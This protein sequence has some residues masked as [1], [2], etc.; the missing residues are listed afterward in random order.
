MRLRKWLTTTLIGISLSAVGCSGASHPSAAARPRSAGTVAETDSA[1]AQRMFDDARSKML[2]AEAARTDAKPGSPK[3][4]TREKAPHIRLYLEAATAFRAV[5]EKYPM[6]QLSY[7]A[8]FSLAEALYHA[9]KYEEAAR[10]YRWVRDHRELGTAHSD[11][12][13][14]GVVDSYE[15][16]IEQ[17]QA[18]GNAQLPQVPSADDLADPSRTQPIVMGPLYTEVQRA[19]DESIAFARSPTEAGRWALQA[20]F[21]SLRHREMDDA[22]R[23]LSDVMNSY[24]RTQAA[25]VAKENLLIIYK[26]RGD[27]AKYDGL[28]RANV[29]CTVARADKLAGL[30]EPHKGLDA[31]MKLYAAGKLEQAATQFEAIAAKAPAGSPLREVAMFDAGV[32]HQEAGE[33]NGAVRVLAPFVD[34]AD[35]ASSP[36]RLEA[37]F[38]LAQAYQVTPDPDRAVATFLRFHADSAAPTAL[39]RAQFDLAAARSDALWMAASMRERQGKYVDP[40]NTK[41]STSAAALYQRFADHQASEKQPDS[42][43]RSADALFRLA[44]VYEKAGQ[45]KEMI[46]TLDRWRRARPTEQAE[47]LALMTSYFMTAKALDRAGDR[48]GADKNYQ[49]TI[50]VYQDRKLAEQPDLL[51]AQLAGEAGFNIAEH[52]F[53]RAERIEVP[54][55]GSL[56]G[57]SG[58]NN[59]TAT[60][61]AYREITEEIAK[62]YREV[63]KL[64]SKWS[65]AAHVRLGDLAYFAG[66]KLAETPKG[67]SSALRQR[68]TTEARALM[69][70]GL[71]HWR[72]AQRISDGQ[73]LATMWS[74]TAESR[75]REYGTGQGTPA[76]IS[77]GFR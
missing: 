53:A 30:S 76:A 1:N 54:W 34:E 35:F 73:Q 20:A 77:A 70:A 59:I 6:S 27:L 72:Q 41:D 12:A 4:T 68:V 8:T 9:E 28:Q 7:E 75:I 58:Q 46:A 60:L 61:R 25:T 43:A 62:P 40:A 29:R 67:M 57:E 13:A 39:P 49:L 10:H 33:P 52:G 65:V 15:R 37:M 50:Q 74:K 11:R 36:L 48:K 45:L 26:V 3:M 2:Y 18:A 31:A 69:D 14:A 22:E 24:C 66:K 63:L 5:L 55:S 19:Y 21:I 38:R 16:A 51:P 32:A 23:R 47:A 56:S 17:A 64:P 71:E 44:L 42:A